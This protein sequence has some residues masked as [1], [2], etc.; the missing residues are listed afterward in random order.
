MRYDGVGRYKQTVCDLFVRQPLYHTYHYLF[1][2]TAQG[3][4]AVVLIVFRAGE[5]HYLIGYS[6]RCVVDGYGLVI[7]LHGLLVGKGVEQGHKAQRSALRFE[8]RNGKPR[9]HGRIDDQYVGFVTTK[10]RWQ[11]GDIGDLLYLYVERRQTPQHGQYTATYNQR[12][13][14]ND[15]FDG[16]THFSRVRLS[17]ERTT[18]PPPYYAKPNPARKRRYQTTRH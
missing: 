3:I 2:T 5:T 13:L 14:E 9:S 12:R 4:G 11:L 1:L 15:Y 16:S 7:Q 6:V 10:R 18:H 8:L 17:P